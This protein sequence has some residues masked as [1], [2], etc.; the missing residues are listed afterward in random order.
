MQTTK[1]KIS[2]L[3]F[4]AFYIALFVLQMIPSFIIMFIGINTIWF[5][6]IC[7]IGLAALITQVIQFPCF[8]TR[9]WNIASV[10]AVIGAIVVL[11][12]MG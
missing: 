6:I 9:V 3:L 1:E 11:N 2:D 7:G 5:W 12:L 8:I 10:G 4:G